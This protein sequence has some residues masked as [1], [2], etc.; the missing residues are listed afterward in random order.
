MLDPDIT[1]VIKSINRDLNKAT[2]LVKQNQEKIRQI[3]KDDE[4][5]KCKEI[6]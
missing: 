6:K 4:F 5:C 3:M 1:Y 2:R